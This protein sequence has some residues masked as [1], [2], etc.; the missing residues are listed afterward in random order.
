MNENTIQNIASKYQ[1]YKMQS[2]K[3]RQSSMIAMQTYGISAPNFYSE[4][5]SKYKQ[6]KKKRS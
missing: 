5:A 6:K 4:L 1:T 3:Q 2:E